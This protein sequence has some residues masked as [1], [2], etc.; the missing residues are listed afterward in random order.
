MSLA[1]CR[2]TNAAAPAAN[3]TTFFEDEW[4]I[5]DPE[6]AALVHCDSGIAGRKTDTESLAPLLTSDLIES[7][8]DFHVYADLPG[9][10]VNDLEVSIDDNQLVI[11]AERKHVHVVGSDKI[12]SM[13]RSYGKVMRS[14]RIPNNVDLNK[15]ETLFRNGV[16]SV[17]FPKMAP[18]ES[19]SR[20]LSIGV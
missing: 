6:T 18:A 20:K 15:V 1:H 16:L 5:F 3:P 2:P 14:M 7:D 8:T 4:S 19:S 10:D 11:K 9:V 17:S 13:E 12:H